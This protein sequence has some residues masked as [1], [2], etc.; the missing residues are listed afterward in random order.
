MLGESGSNSKPSSKKPNAFTSTLCVI[1]SFLVNCLHYGDAATQHWPAAG[2]ANLFLSHA[3]ANSLAFVNI[4]DSNALNDIFQ[5]SKRLLL[6]QRNQSVWKVFVALNTASATKNSTSLSPFKLLLIDIVAFGGLKNLMLTQ[7]LLGSQFFRKEAHLLAAKPPSISTVS[8]VQQTDLLFSRE[9][10]KLSH[11]H[12]VASDLRCYNGT[13]GEVLQLICYT[14]AL[15]VRQKALDPAVRLS[16]SSRGFVRVFAEIW[17]WMGAAWSELLRGSDSPVATLALTQYRLVVASL[18]LLHEIT[19]SPCMGVEELF[20]LTKYASSEDNEATE[21][22]G[23]CNNAFQQILTLLN[24]TLDKLEETSEKETNHS[25]LALVTTL[26]V[27]LLVNTMRV[28]QND[29]VAAAILEKCVSLVTFFQLLGREISCGNRVFGI[30]DKQRLWAALL[31]LYSRVVTKKLLEEDFFDQTVFRKLLQSSVTGFNSRL[32]A[33]M[34]L[35]VL[36]ELS[37]NR[38]GNPSVNS[39]L[40]LSELSVKEETVLDVTKPS[41]NASSSS[42]AASALTSVPSDRIQL[43]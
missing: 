10:G 11:A 18:S 38:T 8:F 23:G 6:L 3:K 13:V 20:G 28:R 43:S 41:R 24:A 22:D 7:N 15:F 14:K 40:L 26:A 25:L 27:E 19:V 33:L 1:F 37:C 2:L 34:F 21:E 5:Q 36:C 4:V 17:R 32:G 42:F 9:F 31:Q 29:A 39:Q 30:M 16:D 12:D 35:E